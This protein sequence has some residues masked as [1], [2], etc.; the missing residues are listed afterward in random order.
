MYF[1][2]IEFNQNK[3]KKAKKNHLIL[4]MNFRL[5]LNLILV[6]VPLVILVVLIIVYQNSRVLTKTILF[7][8]SSTKTTYILGQQSEGF[9]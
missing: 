7:S 5:L 3:T 1:C 9:P 4:V 8:F 2:F 6:I